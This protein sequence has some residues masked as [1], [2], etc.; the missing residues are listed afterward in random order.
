[1]QNE[2]PGPKE[3]ATEINGPLRRWNGWMTERENTYENWNDATNRKKDN[4][5]N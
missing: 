2:S 5:E 4:N 1:M 3:E